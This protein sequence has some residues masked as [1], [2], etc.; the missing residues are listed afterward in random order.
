MK[1]EIYKIIIHDDENIGWTMRS[2]L[3]L[4]IYKTIRYRNDGLAARCLVLETGRHHEIYVDTLEN[5]GEK[6]A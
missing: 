4:E 6:V 1:G 2:L 5:N 3:V